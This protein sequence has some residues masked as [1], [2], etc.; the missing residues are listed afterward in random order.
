MSRFRRSELDLL[1]RFL[2]DATRFELSAQGKL[3]QKLREDYADILLLQGSRLIFTPATKLRLRQALAKAEGF[4]LL[5]GLPESV[6]RLEMATHHSDEKLADVAPEANFLLATSRTGLLLRRGLDK[7][8]ESHSNRSGPRA[9]S[10]P[11]GL[12]VRL[13]VNDLDINGYDSIVVVENLQAFDHWHL[14]RVADD[15]GKEL[16]VYRG[17]DVTARAV[18]KLLSIAKPFIVAFTDL[19]PAGLQIACTLPHVSKLLVPELP[20]DHLDASHP[21]ASFNAAIQLETFAKQHKALAFLESRHLAGWQALATQVTKA[22][23]AI[24][25][26][27]MLARGWLLTC[28]TK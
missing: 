10:L 26:E 25:Q 12:S 5:Q 4:D 7:P 21:E 16:V 9:F 19:D 24:M 14:A 27:T 17:H 11:P 20:T 3:G 22:K 2:R 18:L 28:V 1:T 8:T 13:Q 6:N 23:I 15:L